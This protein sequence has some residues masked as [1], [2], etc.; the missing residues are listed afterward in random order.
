MSV[1]IIKKDL[2]QKEV[3]R[4][5]DKNFVIFP[6][7]NTKYEG[8]IKKQGDTVSVQ[9]LPSVSFAT[10][11]AGTDIADSGFTITSENLVVDQVKQLRISVKDLD[12]V[13]SN[14]DLHTKIAQRIAVAQADLEDQFIAGFWND[15]N[16]PGGN[17]LYSGAAVTLTKSNIHDYLEEMRARMGTNNIKGDLA[18]FVD[19][20]RASLVRLSPLFDGYREGLSVRENG[21]AENG[22]V[23]KLAGFKIYESNNVPANRLLA[24]GRDGIHFASQMTKMDVRQATTGFYDNIICELVYGGKIFTETG[25]SVVTLRYA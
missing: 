23:G 24:L 5:L 12:S 1:T 10:G 9:L 18:L 4:N 16:I 14:L 25:K 21:V 19:P 7:A 20:T 17:K 2:L 22:Y 3:L 13:Q 11:T 6:W 15:A 8:E